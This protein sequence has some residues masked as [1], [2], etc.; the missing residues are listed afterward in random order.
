MQS[1]TLTYRDEELE[2]KGHL[3]YD[4]STAERRPAVVVC[5]AI[6]GQDDFAREKAEEIAR[7]GY[8]GFAIDVYG[9]GVAFENIEDAREIHDELENDRLKMRRRLTAGLKAVSSQE[10]VDSHR[11]GAMG[12]CFGGMC[13]LELARSGAQVRGVVSFHGQLDTP[14][15]E[16]AGNIQGKVLALHGYDD[17]LTRARVE[18][19]Q[20]E[21]NEAGVDWQLHAYGGTFHSF[22][23]P[24]ANNREKGLLYDP[25]ADRRS[26]L[27]MTH[28]FEE[29]FS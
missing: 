8:V 11:V 19:F 15:P 12:Y 13:A 24:A 28:F 7:L 17:P 14:H 9:Q 26:W 23:N 20:K 25:A 6:R 29:T 4:H 2:M 18:D 10:R 22:T 1:E 3:V 16:D 27:A 21:M 5:H